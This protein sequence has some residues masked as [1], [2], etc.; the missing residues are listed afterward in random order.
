MIPRTVTML[1]G[2]LLLSLQTVKAVEVKVISGGESAAKAADCRR[3]L[4]GLGVNQPA[5][6]KATLA[7]TSPK[8]P[9]A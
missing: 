3:M 8:A 7:A 4:V 1:A 5:E 2:T 9:W 6:R